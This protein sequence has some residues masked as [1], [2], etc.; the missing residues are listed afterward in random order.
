M[1]ELAI[2]KDKSKLTRLGVLAALFMLLG[3]TMLSNPQ[4]YT[5]PLWNSLNL[6]RMLGGLCMVFFWITVFIGVRALT[7]HT[8]QLTLDQQGFTPRKGFMNK[9]DKPSSGKILW[10]NIRNIRENTINKQRVIEIELNDEDGF[11]GALL[12]LLAHNLTIDHD[13]LIKHFNNYHQAY[14]GPSQPK[15]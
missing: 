8:P 3:V 2:F 7:D 13:S 15:L 11:S 9:G 6:I 4:A 1:D 10:K 12:Y 5:T 14:H